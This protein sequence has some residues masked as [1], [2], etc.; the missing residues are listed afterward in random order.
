[1]VVASTF[2]PRN[3]RMSGPRASAASGQAC[4]NKAAAVRPTHRLKD[5]S[6]RGAGGAELSHAR[7]L[8]RVANPGENITDD[9]SSAGVVDRQ[10]SGCEN[11]SP[12]I[13]KEKH[14]VARGGGD[15]QCARRRHTGR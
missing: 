2:S 1:M 8:L 15:W 10:R 14:K 11:S 5:N 12:G 3:T 4:G 9:R 13:V 7:G 6:A